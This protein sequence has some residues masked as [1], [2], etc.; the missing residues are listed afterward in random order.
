MIKFHQVL[1]RMPSVAL[2]ITRNNEATFYTCD[3]CPCANQLP[4]MRNRD[5]FETFFEPDLNTDKNVSYSGD[6]LQEAYTAMMASV[7]HQSDI[8]PLN[9]VE[10]SGIEALLQVSDSNDK[11]TRC[12]TLLMTKTGAGATGVETHFEDCRRKLASVGV[13]T[14]TDDYRNILAKT[15]KAGIVVITGA[16]VRY[17]R[18]SDSIDKAIDVLEKSDD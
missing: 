4:D 9:D 11:Q 3:V 7:F 18:A 5:V 16:Y 12:V 10:E 15:I 2:T 17:Y 8:A 6:T 13:G 14:M 1:D